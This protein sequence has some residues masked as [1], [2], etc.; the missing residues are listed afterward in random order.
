MKS[1]LVLLI[2]ALALVYALAGCGGSSDSSAPAPATIAPADSSV[3]IEATVLPT[4]TLKSNVETLAANVAGVDDLGAT[5]VE[6]VEEAAKEADEPFSYEKDV[7]SWLG[8][9]AGIF[10]SGFD[11]K[12]FSEAG[13][14]IQVTD[15]SA[16]QE[17]IDAHV[18]PDHG[19]KFEDASYEG[20]DYKVTSDDDSSIGIVGDFIVYAKNQQI[21]KAVV[22]AS[23]G[24]E[25]LADVKKYTDSTSGE[26]SDGLASVYV[27]IGALIKQAGPIDPQ[28]AVFLQSAGISPEEATATATVVPGADQVEIDLRSDITGDNPPSGDASELVG[29]MPAESVAAFASPEF[30]KALSNLI[31][32]ID[33][34]GIPGSIPPH[35]FKEGL[36]S[37]GIDLEKIVGSIGD[38]GGFVEGTSLSNLGGAVVLTTDNA[39][40]A[41]NTVSNIG[42]LLRLSH[43]PGITAIGGKATGFS[44]RS[45]SL[46]HKPIV[47][48][49]KGKRISIGYGLPAALLGLSEAG[50]KLAGDSVYKEAVSALGGTPITAFADGPGVLGLV[51]A[52]SASEDPDFQKAKPYLE[53]VA[54]IAA[55]GG[56]EDGLSTAKLIVGFEK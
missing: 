3:F 25:G 27:D 18:K 22:D 39:A 45:S 53:K 35:K 40:E 30:G 28:A 23:N 16:A 37:A 31:D 19:E 20:V 26:P 24:G 41:S 46:G 48:A 7:K 38:L 11:G 34:N 54:Y 15:T 56:V 55:G 13:G 42:L 33:A 5:V 1:R 6:K 44:I 2:A 36:K 9:K 50:E 43:T 49:A 12:D 32:S 17:F 14:M 10:L 47:V 21:F 52:G 4:G 8:E 29:S 51:E